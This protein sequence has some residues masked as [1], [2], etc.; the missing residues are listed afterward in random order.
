MAK[1][2]IID[3]D[4]TT[5]TLLETLLQ[6]DGFEV[7]SEAR[8]DKILPG[9][10]SAAPDLVLMDVFL[11]HSDGMGVLAD[12]RSEPD[13]ADLRVVMTSGMDLEEQCLAAG[14]NA[15]LLKPYSPDQLAK[16]IQ[17][18]IGADGGRAVDPALHQE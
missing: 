6:M 10:R 11:A 12:L 7:V 8:K 13:L 5:V 3:D 2:M 15:F 18:N 14:A 17:E 9:I 16:V 4:R 1:V